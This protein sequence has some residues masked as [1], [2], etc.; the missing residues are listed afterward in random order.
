[1]WLYIVFLFSAVAVVGP[2][3]VGKSTFLKLLCGDLTPVS[4]LCA[5]VV[6][7]AVKCAG[8]IGAC[9]YS[10]L[11]FELNVCFSG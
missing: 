6:K 2:N 7:P 1:M 9:A 4:L 8:K 10:E 5:L 3:G 11:K